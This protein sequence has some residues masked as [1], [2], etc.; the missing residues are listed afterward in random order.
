MVFLQ[1]YFSVID[2]INTEQS[3]LISDFIYSLY[4]KA[5]IKSTI[6]LITE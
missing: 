4:M 6:T 2:Y 1:Q 3:V 5:K